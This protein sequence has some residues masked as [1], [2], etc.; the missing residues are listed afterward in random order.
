MPPLSRWF[1]F[2]NW[3]RPDA[4]LLRGELLA[5][6]TVALVLVPQ[7]VA[8]ASLAG[9]PLITGLYAALLPGLVAV[10]WSAS[11][12]LSVGPT[13]LTALLVYAS[14]LP[15]AEPASAR[16][17]ELAVWLSLLSGVLQLV[18]GL[19]RAGWLL[20]LVSS[21]VLTGFTQAAALL[22]ISSQLP[23]LLGLRALPRAWPAPGDVD[24]TAAAFGVGALALLV[25]GRRWLPR[26]P[27]VMLVVAGAAGLSWYLAFDGPV[28]GPLPAQLPQPYWPSGLD[29]DTFVRLLAPAAIISLVSFLETAASAKVEN[30][31]EGKRWDDNQDLVGQG[32]AKLASAVSGSFP[33]SA[34][35]SRSAVS[36]Y[37]GARTGWAAV[38][39]A[40]MVVLALLLLTPVLYHVPL[41]VLAAVVVAAV[42]G[43]LKPMTVRTFW[44]VSRVEALIVLVTFGVTLATAPRIYWGVLAGVVL[45]MA[46]FLYQRLHPR[47]IEVGLHP[48]GSLRDRRLWQLP[49]LAPHVFALR[50]DADLDFASASG[51][52]RHIVEHLGRSEHIH[53]I[54]LFAQP[55]NRIDATG[56]EVFGQLRQ[57]LAKRQ[58]VLHISGL[59]LPVE[60][61]LVRA[62]ELPPSPWLKTYRTDAEALA[63]LRALPYDD[64]GPPEPAQV[65][66]ALA[67]EGEGQDASEEKRA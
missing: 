65:Q 67:A 54:C 32:L 40:A 11:T 29:L 41:S 15:L 37:A 28:V 36:L 20:N 25:A 60:S 10:M 35:F 58:T 39:T 50:M 61:L 44:R 53:H 57:L 4:K 8:Y 34:S 51:F 26:V 7:A 59:K 33:T 21:P 49:P 47:I 56:I 16:W 31:R 38:V 48:D 3:P 22:I 66:R 45:A 62:G 30:Q 46:H 14:L 13:A 24:W 1:P 64:V 12:R 42:A 55:I 27:M 18:L 5:G 52:E 9:M 2:L 23:A 17:V 19:L 6:F 43:L 63:A